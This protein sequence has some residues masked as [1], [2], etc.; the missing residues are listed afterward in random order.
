[1]APG[2]WPGAVRS[3]VP[4]CSGLCKPRLKPRGEEGSAETAWSLVKSF[5]AS[6]GKGFPLLNFSVVVFFLPAL[7]LPLPS[8]ALFYF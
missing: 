6:S 1:M 2:T 7:S 8:P 3:C 4:V 5:V